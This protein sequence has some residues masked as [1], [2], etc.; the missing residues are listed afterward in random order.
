MAESRLTR[1]V[2]FRASIRSAAFSAKSSPS[3]NRAPKSLVMPSTSLI[4]PFPVRATSIIVSV[5]VFWEPRTV[6]TESERIFVPAL[7]MVPALSCAFLSCFFM[8]SATSSVN[9][10]YALA[11]LSFSSRTSENES[12]VADSSVRYSVSIDAIPASFSCSAPDFKTLASW[13]IPLDLE[14]LK[15]VPA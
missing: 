2:A 1:N 8:T 15:K 5:E 10:E 12:S 9:D 7:F 13:K 4:F 14:G 6:S 11:M 3:S